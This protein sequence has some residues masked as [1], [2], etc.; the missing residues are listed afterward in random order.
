[1]GRLLCENVENINKV[2]DC[3]HERNVDYIENIF[4]KAERILIVII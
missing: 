3:L 4:S 2:I 1:M